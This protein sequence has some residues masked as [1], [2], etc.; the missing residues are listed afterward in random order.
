MFRNLDLR[1]IRIGF[2][3]SQSQT[4]ARPDGVWRSLVCWHTRRPL[5]VGER[6]RGAGSAGIADVARVR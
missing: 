4:G 1:A 3:E 6:H 5:R 2:N